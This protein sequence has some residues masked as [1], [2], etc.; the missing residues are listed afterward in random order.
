MIRSTQAWGWL[1]A[2]VLALG[3]NGIY[4]DSGAAW[5][6]RSIAE[7]AAHVE[8]RTAPVLALAAGRAEWFLARTQSTGAQGEAASCRLQSA[9]ARVQGRVA[10]AQSGM[11]R[12]EA[13]S[14]RRE[15]AMARVEERMARVEADRAR[16]EARMAERMRITPAL[17]QDG[18]TSIECP[19]VRV[20]V[21]HVDVNVPTVRVETPDVQVDVAGLGP[22]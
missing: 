16:I 14:A 5:V 19:R 21:P 18:E 2:G 7:I 3:L 22:A 1:T 10:H 15:A 4:Q 8:A 9:V 12:Y 13:M 20:R 17:F 11:A 6:H